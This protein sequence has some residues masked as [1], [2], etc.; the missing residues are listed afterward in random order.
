MRSAALLSTVIMATRIGWAA[1]V[2]KPDLQGAP[3]PILAAVTD[4]AAALEASPR[5]AEKWGDYAI[6]LHAH[7]CKPEADIAYAEAQRLNP[8]D[9]RWAYFRGVLLLKIDPAKALEC[10][11]VAVGLDEAYGPAHI[12]RGLA[13]EAVGRDDDARRDYLE[14]IRLEPANVSAHMHLGQLELKHQRIEDAIRHLEIARASRPNDSGVLSS[15]ARAYMRQGDRTRARELAD[16]ARHA[17]PGRVVDDLRF[18][19]VAMRAVTEQAFIDRANVSFQVGRSDRAV[20][21]L[22]TALSHY[23]DS[24]RA[25][26]GLARLY[27]AR[28]QYRKCV[29]SGRKAM[30]AGF[31]GARVDIVLGEGLLNLRRLD[32]AEE[33]IRRALD[34][35]PLDVDALR[36]YG[37]IAAV[38][39]NDPEAV[40]RLTDALAVVDDARIRRARAEARSRLGRHEEAIAELKS[41]LSTA[42]EDSQTWLALGEAHQRVGDLDAALTALDRAAANASLPRAGRQA[43]L[44]LIEQR[45]FAGAERRL[46]DLRKR[47]PRNP[48]LQNDLA[49]LLATCPDDN[50]RNGGEALGLIQPLVLQTQRREPAALDTLAAALAEVG[51]FTEAAAAMEEALAILPADTSAERRV[52]Y[53]TR[54]DQYAQHRAWRND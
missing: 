16:A 40:K 50:V 49:W 37:N 51:R 23:P 15:L 4:A 32:E 18:N 54:R 46:R 38:R 2:P 24:G 30:A 25:H 31:R 33:V 5:S 9:F 48:N 22:Q 44:V 8:S 19:E 39:G 29:E 1:D 10:L 17:N 43:A 53:Q 27:L 34:E 52:A 12:R 35:A 26:Q 41:L 7:S 28:R 42:P 14:A 6:V 21:E 3:R 45:R 11:D 20:A 13:L 47:W 36:L